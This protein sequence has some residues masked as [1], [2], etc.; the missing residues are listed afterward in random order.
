MKKVRVIGMPHAAV[1]H[2]FSMNCGKKFPSAGVGRC[3]L[4]LSNQRG[5]NRWRGFG[6]QR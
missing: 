1:M 4:P 6:E 5:D 3:V 2:S